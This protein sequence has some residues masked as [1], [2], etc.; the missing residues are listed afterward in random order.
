MTNPVVFRVGDRVALRAA[1]LRSIMDYSHASASRRG[2]VIGIE[3]MGKWQLV[4]I[5]GVQW[6]GDPKRS[7]KVLSCNLVHADRIHLEPA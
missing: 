4:E 2:E 6:A 3:P 1:F 7:F 5:Y